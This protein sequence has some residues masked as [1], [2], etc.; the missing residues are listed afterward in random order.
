M[1]FGE[2][3]QVPLNGFLFIWQAVM[4]H[5]PGSQK[6]LSGRLLI[7]KAPHQI[8]SVSGMFAFFLTPPFVSPHPLCTFMH[9]AWWETSQGWEER[10]I[11]INKPNEQ[12]FM[13]ILVTVMEK[14]E[15]ILATCLWL[16][17][18]NNQ[19]RAIWIWV[20]GRGWNIYSQHYCTVRPRPTSF[21]KP[22][23]QIKFPHP[24]KM[25]AKP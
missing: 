6:R 12:H 1:L 21:N 24:T 19:L 22:K 18:M 4:F 14:L 13:L 11:R 5:Y 16:V 23:T 7:F 15:V 8:L 9:G 25:A 10:D 17:I 2:E 20:C 3:R